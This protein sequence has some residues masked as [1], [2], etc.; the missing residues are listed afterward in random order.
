MKIARYFSTYCGANQIR[1]F[2]EFFIYYNVITDTE[3]LETPDRM[4]KLLFHKET[5]L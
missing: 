2:G 3:S 4:H 1:S 5:L